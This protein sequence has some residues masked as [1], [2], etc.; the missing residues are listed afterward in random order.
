MLPVP[1]LVPL[2]SLTTRHPDVQLHALVPLCSGQVGSAKASA[3][4]NLSSLGPPAGKL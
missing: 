4:D 2:T 1:P 3:S